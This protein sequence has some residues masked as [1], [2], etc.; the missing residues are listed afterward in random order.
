MSDL[1]KRSVACLFL[2]ATCAAP[3]LAQDRNELLRARG[4]PLKSDV[5]IVAEIGEQLASTDPALRK[6]GMEA[7]RARIQQRGLAELRTTWFKTLVRNK[8]YEELVDISR[9]GILA[10]PH[11]TRNIE[12]VLQTRIKTLI[13]LGRT[14]EALADAR[15][16]FN[17]SGMTGTADA[18]LAVAE[19]LGA[20]YSNDPDIYN[21][22]RDEQVAGVGPPTTAAAAAAATQPATRPVVCTILL[23]IAID[24]APFDKAIAAIAGEDAQSLLGKGNLLL[25][26]ARP[27]E[28][29]AV[30]EKMYS[31]AGADLVEA[32]E[33]LARCLKA[34]DGTIGRANAYV[35]SL[36][37]KR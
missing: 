27:A 34:E 28:A 3:T 35:M 32:S 5:V 30:F 1:V 20:A 15:G 33:S 21:R 37:P 22:F 36:R 12:A 4:A 14:K 24:P 26:S 19:A 16:L 31:L 9:D 29:R 18:I 10:H 11:D 2:L 7:L 17:V 8:L 25:L 13:V 6:Q 23:D